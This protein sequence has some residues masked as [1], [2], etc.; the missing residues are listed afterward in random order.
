MNLQLIQNTEKSTI[1]FTNSFIEPNWVARLRKY[2][3]TFYFLSRRRN[4]DNILLWPRTALWLW[5]IFEYIFNQFVPMFIFFNL[6]RRNIRSNATPSFLFEKHFQQFWFAQLVAFQTL[7]F[8]VP[9]DKRRNDGQMCVLIASERTLRI[10]V[11][12]KKYWWAF[13]TLLPCNC[14]GKIYSRRTIADIGDHKVTAGWSIFD[15]VLLDE[16][17]SCKNKSN[18]IKSIQF[19]YRHPLAYHRCSLDTNFFPNQVC[20]RWNRRWFDFLDFSPSNC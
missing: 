8:L 3:V 12:A 15:T 2:S 16:R 6:S 10:F 20:C 17:F 13:W 14:C 5:I 1:R 19:S 4:G 18:K 11:T 9:I 7:R